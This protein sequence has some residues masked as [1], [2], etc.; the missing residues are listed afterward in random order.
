[1]LAGAF[2]ISCLTKKAIFILT[3]FMTI[4]GVSIA[5]FSVNLYMGSVGLFINYACK[6]IQIELIYCYINE[7]VDEAKRG[8]HQTLIFMF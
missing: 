8:K 7:T 6:C 4:V 1:V 2:L 5:L 3:T